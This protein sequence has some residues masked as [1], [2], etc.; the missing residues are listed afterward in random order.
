MSKI[1]NFFDE[2]YY[3]NLDAR[4]DRRELFETR[5]KE[6]GIS[7]KRFSAIQL[8]LDMIPSGALDD[9][10]SREATMSTEDRDVMY[11]NKANEIGCAMSHKA[12]VKEA[13][14]HGLQNVLIF[15]DDCKFLPDWNAEIAAVVADLSTVEWDVM[16]FGGE[17]NS[18]AVSIT[19][20]L[21]LVTDGGVYCCHSYAVH[22]RFFDTI[23]NF[24]LNQ[25][26]AIDLFL[27][28]CDTSLRKYVVSKK[29]LTIQESNWSDIRN[30]NTNASQIY[31]IN[32]WKRFIK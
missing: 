3:I 8:G 6:A 31:L 18:D 4:V 32:S 22:R 7:A 12:V 10:R 28:H 25:C 27:L 30:E 29:L 1:L 20:N 19:N 17:L 21:N 16:Y 2:A 24:D 5:S 13:H 23:I 15:E 26:P 11:R 14:D 9:L